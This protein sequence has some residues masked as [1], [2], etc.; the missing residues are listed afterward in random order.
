LETVEGV[1]VYHCGTKRNDAGDFATNGGR[2]LAVVAQAPTRE[3]ARAKV[4]AEA[5]KIDF[6]GSQRRSDI[7]KL[8]FE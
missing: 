3:E 7:A 5:A 2:V 8:H 6:P 4:Y 1:R